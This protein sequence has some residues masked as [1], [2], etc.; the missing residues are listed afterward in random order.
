VEG[1]DKHAADGLG[2]SVQS[3]VHVFL[4]LVLPV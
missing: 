2:E 1:V 4:S 3:R